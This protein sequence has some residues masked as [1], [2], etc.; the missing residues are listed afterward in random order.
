MSL[1]SSSV[2]MEDTIE[3]ESGRKPFES[4]GDE[5]AEAS[6]RLNFPVK[7]LQRQPKCETYPDLQKIIQVSGAVKMAQGEIRSPKDNKTH[8]F[9]CRRHSWMSS[10]STSSVCRLIRSTTSTVLYHPRKM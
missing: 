9:I 5:E 8:A 4:G 10:R 1:F 6:M 2:D 7:L 3:A